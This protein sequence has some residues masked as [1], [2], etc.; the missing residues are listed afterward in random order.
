MRPRRLDAVRFFWIVIDRCDAVEPMLLARLRDLQ[1]AERKALLATLE[2]NISATEKALDAALAKAIDAFEDYTE[3]LRQLDV[4][5]F[6]GAISLA[7]A[8][9][10]GEGVLAE[11]MALERWRQQREFLSDA[12]AAAVMPFV[13]PAPAPPKVVPLKRR[14][15][16]T[17]DPRA[18]ARP[19]PRA[20]RKLPGP[21]ER[22]TVRIEA[23]MANADFAGM[24][25]V[26][27][28]QHD[29]S[30]EEADYILRGS[31]FKFVASAEIVEDAAQ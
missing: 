20:P 2:N 31:A 8:P 16:E 7:S 23:V 26:V 15:I 24:Q 11:R 25:S 30:R 17:G 13:P 27:G 19:T 6:T 21:I 22:G 9:R 1:S 3:S 4:M 10:V 29:I 14:E 12:A 5:G 28:D 18:V